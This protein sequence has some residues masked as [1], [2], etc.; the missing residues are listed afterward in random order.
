MSLIRASLYIGALKT[1]D[2]F[3]YGCCLLFVLKRK[4]ENKIKIYRKESNKMPYNEVIV[5]WGM[6]DKY[7]DFSGFKK[8]YANDLESLENFISYF[9]ALQLGLVSG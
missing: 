3:L 5:A 2:S 6:K 9:N 4:L 1:E 8:A 7:G